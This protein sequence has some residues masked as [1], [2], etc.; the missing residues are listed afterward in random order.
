MQGDS[1]LSGAVRVRCLAQVVQVAYTSTLS[2]EEPAIELANLKL[3][4]DPL[5]RLIGLKDLGKQSNCDYF[6]QYCDY[7]LVRDF[8]L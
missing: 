1:Q 3:P 4:A 6:I 5:Y 8:S 7:D 2:W